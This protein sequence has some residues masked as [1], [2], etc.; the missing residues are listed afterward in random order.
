MDIKKTIIFSLGVWLFLTILFYILN[1]IPVLEKNIYFFT[2]VWVFLIIKLFFL[3]K[4]YF[5]KTTINIK[6]GFILGLIS[7]LVSAILIYFVSFNLLDLKIENESLY[8]SVT[9]LEIL[10]F[11]TYA[12]FEFDKTFTESK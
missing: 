12:G 6:N 2:V 1:L 7:S 5:R 3:S 4:W 9:F 11:C 8:L 10:L